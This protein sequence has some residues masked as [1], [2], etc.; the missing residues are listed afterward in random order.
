MTKA[1]IKRSLKIVD[2]KKQKKDIAEWGNIAFIRP[3]PKKRIDLSS[4]KK[5]DGILK[6]TD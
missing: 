2:Q 3:E 1:I 5:V 6:I 4:L